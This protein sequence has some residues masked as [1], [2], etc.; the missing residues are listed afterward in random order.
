MIKNKTFKCFFFLVPLPC[1]SSV[2]FWSQNFLQNDC[3]EYFTDNLKDV[4]IAIKKSNLNIYVT[5]EDVL[6]FFRAVLHKAA[7]SAHFLVLQMRASRPR[8]SYSS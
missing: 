8:S 6:D 1:L 7:D 2:F 5:S 3:F 4:C